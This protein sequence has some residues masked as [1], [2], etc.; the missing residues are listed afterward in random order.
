[1]D[2]ALADGLGVERAV[3]AVRDALVAESLRGDN[4]DDGKVA[5][6]FVLEGF[7]FGPGIEAVEDDAF[8]A[9][10]DEIL[11][12]GDGLAGN[13]I[14]TF[15]VANH[16]AEGFLGLTIRGAGDAAFSHFLINHATKI[17]LGVAVI[18][19]VINGD[20]F[21]TAAHADNGENFYISRI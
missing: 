6:E 9:G 3:G 11:S 17:N 14:F 15:G 18:G 1:M 4:G 21:A 20:G 2:I 8:L 13:P 5:G 16:G 7:V 12:L 19:K 10:F